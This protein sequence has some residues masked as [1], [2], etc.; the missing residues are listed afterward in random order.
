MP[1]TISQ[2]KPSRAKQKWCIK[3]GADITQ[4]GNQAKHCHNCVPI[5]YLRHLEANKLRQKEQRAGLR[6]PPKPQVFNYKSKRPETYHSQQ[7]S[8][9]GRDFLIY[10]GNKLTAV[11]MLC[12]KCKKD[13]NQVRGHWGPIYGQ[14][15]DH[16]NELYQVLL[17]RSCYD[18]ECEKYGAQTIAS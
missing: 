12:R 4:R 13:N 17:C 11:P 15:D 5:K 18:A 10:V 3:C 7:I 16:G 14:Y 8:E 2:P 9:D 6:P 1:K